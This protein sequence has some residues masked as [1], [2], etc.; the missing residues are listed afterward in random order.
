MFQSLYWMFKTNNFK[1]HFL[2]LLRTYLLLNVFALIFAGCS[3]FFLT[4]NIFYQIVLYAISA[5]LFFASHLFLTGYFWDLTCCIAERKSDVQA[6]SVYSKHMKIKNIITI[7]LPDISTKKFIWRGIASIVATILLLYPLAA[8]FVISIAGGSFTDSVDITFLLTSYGIM[9][10]ILGSF[11]PAL[12]WNYAVRNSVIAVWNIFK[13]I[14]IMGT[15]TLQ[16]FWNTFLFL[17]F[18]FIN[19]CIMTLISNIVGTDFTLASDI[20]A[21]LKYFVFIVISCSVGIYWL[22][23]NAFLLGTIAPPG[24][25]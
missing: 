21:Y 25:V 22:F 7:T 3:Y 17:L 6:S 23:V 5:L 1:Q 4:D 19:Y 24:E 10:L 20:Y 15:Y 18:V 16:Y 13:A 11:I 9:F 2:Y 8:L 14:H 12:L